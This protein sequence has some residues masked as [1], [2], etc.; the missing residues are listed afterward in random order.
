VTDFFLYLLTL[1]VGA[2]LGFFL[3][4]LF[5]VNQ[6]LSVSAL[7]NEIVKHSDTDCST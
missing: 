2:L 3:A 1:N 7:P 5:A 4:S 6:S